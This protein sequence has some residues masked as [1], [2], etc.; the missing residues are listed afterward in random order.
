MPL[1]QDVD[2]GGPCVVLLLASEPRKKTKMFFLMK[3]NMGTFIS[4]CYSFGVLKQ[5]V[6]CELPKVMGASCRGLND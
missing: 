1:E 2:K 5:R 4:I 3:G 6:E